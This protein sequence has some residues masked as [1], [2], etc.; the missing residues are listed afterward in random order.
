MNIV[1]AD[2]VTGTITIRMR[3]VPWDQALDVVLQAKGLGH[4][5]PGQPHPRGAARAAP[6]GA[7]AQASPQ[8]KQEL[9]LDAARDAA[10]PH[11]LR[12]GRGARRRA[13]RSCSRRAARS[14]STS[15]PTCSSRATSPGTS[16]TSRSSSAR[17]TRRPRRCSSRRESSRRRAST[18]A[19][20]A[21][22]GAATSTF[23][24]ATGN[25][26]GVAFPSSISAAGG[27]YDNN[28]PTAGLSPFTRTV[29]NPNFAVNLPAAVG[30]GAGGAL[31]MTFGSIDNTLNLSLRLSAAESS[32]L[33]AHRERARASWSSTTSEA[34]INQGTL[35][36]FSQ[37][38]AQGVQTTFQEAK[39]QL[40]VKPH[41]T[42]DGSRLDAR[43]AQP[44][45][46]G[47][48]PD[49]PRAAIRRSSSARPRRTSS[50]WTATPRSSAASTP[51]TPAATSIRCRSSA[52]SR[53]S[54][55]LFQRRRA[56]DT[57][58]EL[59]IFITPRIVNRAEALGDDARAAHFGSAHRGNAVALRRRVARSEVDPAGARSFDVSG[60]G[61]I[62]PVDAECAGHRLGSGR[63]VSLAVAA[64][65]G[66]IR[67]RARAAAPE[68]MAPHLA[69]E[70]GTIV[71]ESKR[72][73]ARQGNAVVRTVIG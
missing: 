46:A 24:P 2:N 27:N 28:T 56:S 67:A 59:V 13:R 65:V 40:L 12:A 41:V 21:S 16:T 53:S 55:I 29:A 45:R 3:N 47:L 68:L 15:G 50:S 9:E 35:I 11:Q 52:T 73:F 17:S 61:A 33:R 25:P 64:L 48:Q 10:D 34:R 60:R 31:G 49:R 54:A 62:V 38:S 14:R 69:V 66:E 39:L 51:A 4:G 26:T 22:S 71:I 57:R 72:L 30:T 58:G 42:A 43:E 1:T 6:E 8:Q 63:I 19:T 5:A 18:L 7:R 36:P 37:V 20:S 32:G 70:G 23:S 44:R